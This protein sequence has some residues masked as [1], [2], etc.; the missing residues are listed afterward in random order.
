MHREG[1]RALGE[2]GPQRSG[3]ALQ[4]LNYR[5]HLKAGQVLCCPCG[6]RHRHG[7]VSFKSSS[8]FSR[9]TAQYPSLIGGFHGLQVLYVC[10]FS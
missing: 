4:K 5:L 6:C 1:S 8:K 9:S 2:F 7:S 10:N 3:W